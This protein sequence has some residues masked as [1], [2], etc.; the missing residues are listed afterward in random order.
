MGHKLSAVT[1]IRS[2]NFT[3]PGN[4]I[5]EIWVGNTEIISRLPFGDNDLEQAGW[6]AG[7]MPKI[8]WHNF[9]IPLK[10]D[11][12][13][14]A[15][16]TG[17]V[18]LC[19]IPNATVD[20]IVWSFSGCTLTIMGSHEDIAW[21]FKY[22]DI[23]LLIGAIAWTVAAYFCLSV[24]Q[25]ARRNKRLVYDPAARTHYRN[26]VHA[27][28]RGAFVATSF[29]IVGAVFATFALWFWAQAEG[30]C[31]LSK[32][33]HWRL[34]WWVVMAV[35]YYTNVLAG[36]ALGDIWTGWLRMRREVYQQE[37]LSRERRME[38]CLREHNEAHE[39]EREK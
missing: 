29:W 26:D 36:L 4:A 17:P 23:V 22:S 30:F 21:L 13:I 28:Q 37:R 10:R 34:V 18:D 6:P 11:L 5:N 39:P 7:R 9:I 35:L 16:S 20:R 25:R 38:E 24:P 12:Q 32:W 15:N 19:N 14:V 2:E 33:D 1:G 3:E 31:Q 8:P 27:F